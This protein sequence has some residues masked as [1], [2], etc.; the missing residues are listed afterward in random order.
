MKISERAKIFMPFDALKGF[1]EALKEQEKVKVD[2]IELSEDQMTAISHLLNIVKKGMLLKVIYYS[3]QDLNYLVVEG[4][5]TKINFTNREIS[6]VKTIIS[7][8]DI[9]DIVIK[10]TDGLNN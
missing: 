3:K 4:I 1:R 8:D 2:K 5:V 9:Y 10:E 7:I 6:I